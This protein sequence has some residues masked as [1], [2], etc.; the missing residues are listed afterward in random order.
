[1]SLENNVNLE[2]RLVDVEYALSKGAAI[3]VLGVI[4]A[5][6][7]M[8]L[9]AIQTIGGLLGMIVSAPFAPLSKT[10]REI[11]RRSASHFA[12]GLANIT[13]GALEAIPIVGS[14]IFGCRYYKKEKS[15]KMSEKIH[16][17]QEHTILVGYYK[18]EDH[19]KYYDDGKSDDPNDIIDFDKDPQRLEVMKAEANE[20]IWNNRVAPLIGL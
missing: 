7:K 2:R 14:A 20:R 12:N 6:M 15:A 17:G 5:T 18:L 13:S 11:C 16:T 19:P 8:A 4:P 1:M 10:G 9:G 3:P